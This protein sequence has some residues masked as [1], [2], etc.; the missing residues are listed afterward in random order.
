MAELIRGPY[1]MWPLM[2]VRTQIVPSDGVQR[3]A[4]QFY[5][6]VPRPL[7]QYFS[8]CHISTHRVWRRRWKVLLGAFAKLRR[9]TVSFVMSA[10]RS[11][12]PHGTTR[13]PLHGSSWNLIF[14][15][16][17]KACRENSGLTPRRLMSYIYGAPIL[18]V[19]RSHTTTQHSR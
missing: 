4:C 12:R 19:S 16:F 11:V 7:G 8:C 9:T 1:F 2:L 6:G 3:S 14:E 5:S 13:L 18:D 10:Y 17:P 15:Y